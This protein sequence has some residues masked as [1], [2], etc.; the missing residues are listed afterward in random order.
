VSKKIYYH[1]KVFGIDPLPDQKLDED[2][3][4]AHPVS[5]PCKTCNDSGMVLNGQ[6]DGNGQIMMPCPDCAGEPAYLP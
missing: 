6:V 4:P 2:P 5:R 3:S 1:W